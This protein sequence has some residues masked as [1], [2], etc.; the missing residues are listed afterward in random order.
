MGNWEKYLRESNL[1]LMVFTKDIPKDAKAMEQLTECILAKKPM[2]F[3]IEATFTNAQQYLDIIPKDLIKGV[4]Y[5]ND[6]SDFEPILGELIKRFQIDYKIDQ[7]VL[8]D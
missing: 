8:T 1:I 7:V 4:F 5:Y 2:V 6:S 3:L